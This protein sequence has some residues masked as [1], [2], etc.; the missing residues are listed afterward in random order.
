VSRVASV[1][2]PACPRPAPAGRTRHAPWEDL[3]RHRHDHGFAALVLSGG[4]VEA[5]DTGRH[6]VEAGDVVVHRAFESHLDRFDARGAEVLVLPLPRGWDGP[7]CGRVA[8][9]DA[10][11][12]AAERDPLD[13]A[14]LLLDGL[15]EAPPAAMDWPDA[16]AASLRADPD[17]ALAGWAEAAGLHLGSISR[18]FRQVFAVT[19]A[20][21]RLAQRAHRAVEA[22]Q[23]RPHPLAVIA[24]DCGFADQAHMTRAV[25]RLTGRTPS[26]LRGARPTRQAQP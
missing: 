3:A 17:L 25:A 10:V 18:G 2:C 20:A 5:G 12:R 9:P 19:P 8:E 7:A 14:R 13:A 24:Q 15:R 1:P 22:I 23:R 16:L 11:V 4:Y 21:F 26:A 6:R